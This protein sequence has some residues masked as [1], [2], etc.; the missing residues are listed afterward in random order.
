MKK[1]FFLITV[2]SL[3][4]LIGCSKDNNPVSTTTK[5]SITGKVTDQTTGNIISGASITTIPATS[6]VMSDNS[7]N[8]TINNVEAGSYSVVITMNGYVT[9]TSAVNVSA[10]QT[11]TVNVTLAPNPIPDP[12]AAF[13]YGGTLVTPAAITFT[14]TSQ[15]ADTYLW[16][17]GDGTTSTQQNPS[18]TYNQHGTYTVT[19]TASN[20]VTSLSNQTSQTLNIKPGKVFLQTITVNDI[21]LTKPSGGGWDLTSGPDVYFTII[22]SVGTVIIDGSGSIY[23]DV[24]QSMLPL[25]W[26]FTPEL[27]FEKTAWNKTYFIRV[28]DWDATGDEIIGTTNGFKITQLINA[29]YPTSIILQSSNAETNVGLTFRWQ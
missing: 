4:M 27:P 9:N 24:T 10:G 28:W 17:F 18:K 29:N 23:N 16:D 20:S 2:I 14:N 15:Y 7:G 22:D 5:G 3:V 11:S 21:P 26:Q 13:N 8:Y 1:L 19:L 6:S 12:I 25:S